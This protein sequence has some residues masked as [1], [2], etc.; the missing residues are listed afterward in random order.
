ML[1]TIDVGNTNT[2][3]CVFENNKIVDRFSVSSD[4][5]KTSDE[6]G[7]SIYSILSQ[8]KLAEKISDV[9]ISSVVLPLDDILSDA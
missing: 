1:L 4:I 2:S 3:F 5:K 9:A 8:K 7:V 6:Y